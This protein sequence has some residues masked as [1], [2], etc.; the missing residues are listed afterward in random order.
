MNT[1][2]DKDSRQPKL[3]RIPSHD[4]FRFGVRFFFGALLGLLVGF[5][6]WARCMDAGPEGWWFLPGTAGILGLAA[7][8]WG[9]DFWER[10]KDWL[11][12]M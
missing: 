1:A 8:Y 2:R 10:L 9:D 3:K 12:W 5:S 6:L 7:A 4:G 11:W